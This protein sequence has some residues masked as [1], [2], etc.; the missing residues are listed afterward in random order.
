MSTVQSHTRNTPMKLVIRVPSSN[1]SQKAIHRQ[2]MNAGL[3]HH[4][5]LANDANAAGL[6]QKLAHARASARMQGASFIWLKKALSAGEDAMQQWSM[7]EKRSAPQWAVD[8]YRTFWGKVATIYAARLQSFGKSTDLGT[9]ESLPT[10]LVKDGICPTVITI[11]GTPFLFKACRYKMEKDKSCGNG[12]FYLKHPKSLRR[13]K[14]K[15]GKHEDREFKRVEKSWSSNIMRQNPG[16]RWV[17][18]TDASSPLHGRHI[19]IVP[20]A[21]GTASIVWAPEHSGLT[22]KILQPKRKEVETEETKREKLEAEKKREEAKAKRREEMPEEQIEK[23]EEQRKEVKAGRAKA[24]GKL[25]EMIR[26]KAGVETEVTAKERRA[27]EKKIEKLSKPEQQVE[28]LREINEIHRERRKALNEIIADAKKVML[29]E[30][31]GID[32]QHADDKKKIA[33]VIRDN[34]EEFLQAHYAIKAHERTLKVVNKQLRTGMV[35][36]AGTDIIGITEI[37]KEDLHRMVSD[38]KALSDEIAAHYDLIVQTRGGIDQDGKEITGT[39][40]GR[41]DMDKMIA[42]GSL[43]AINGITGEMTGTSMIS[44][45]FM[46]ELGGGNAAILA[47]YYLRNTLG[48]DDYTHHIEHF[49]EYIERKGNEIALDAVQKGDKYLEQAKRVGKF[50]QGEGMLFATRQQGAAAKLAYVNRAYLAYGQAEGGLHMAAEL[51]YQFQA[52]KKDLMI[53]SSNRPALNAKMKRLGLNAGDVRIERHGHGDYSMHIKPSAYEKMI[54]EKVVA[55]YK[56]ITEEPSPQSIKMQRENQAEWLPV[57][58]KSFITNKDGSMD[59]IIPAGE[60]QA[61]ARLVAFQKKVYLNHAPGVGKSFS[62]ILAKAHIE[63]QTGKPVKTVISMPKKLMGNFAEEVK[64]FSD[65]KVVIVDHSDQSKRAEAYKAD[66]NT[67]VL[68]NK[69]KFYFDHDLV[70]SAGFNMVIADEAHKITQR[71]ITGTKGIEIGSKMS[72]GLAKIAKDV[73]YYV[74]G[75]G[76]PSPNDLSE[77]HFHLNIMDPQKYSNKQEFMEKYRHL[78]KGAGLKEKLQNILNAELDDRIYTIEKTVAGAN[79]NYQAHSADLAPKQRIEYQRIQKRFLKGRINAMGR[80]QR[81]SRILNDFNHKENPKYV[82]MKKIIDSH[83]ANKGK[84][85]KV[86]IYAKN[87]STV[88]EI[89]KFVRANYPGKKVVRFTGVD[90]DGRPMSQAR[91]AAAKKSYLKD[92]N[93]LF[94]VHTDA[95]TEGLNLQHT[96]EADRPFGATTVI[97]MASGAHSWSTL[98]QF[99]SRGYRRGANKD[100]HGHLILTDTPHDMATEERLSEKKAVMSMLHEGSQLDEMAALK[101]KV[102]A[103]SASYRLRGTAGVQKSILIRRRIYA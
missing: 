36:H 23:L 21:N 32:E 80:D 52:H 45:D 83:V 39:G 25:H 11:P 74:A 47:D 35:T 5:R 92:P 34:A 1:R 15:D 13:Y 12:E 73:E 64:K 50:T 102:A 10:R 30:E 81:I 103:A 101:Q 29:G 78:H 51:L 91:I 70:K 66:P 58:I 3:R 88:S 49:N 84:S 75:S 18:I 71:D 33:Q 28:R 16:A 82:Q 42:Q 19:L 63:E 87:Y 100:V 65:Y 98:D 95:G 68:V 6:R 41:K 54:K 53:K 76:T 20:H 31:I 62:Y 86:L 44:E 56:Q 61:S 40:A 90:K 7:Y 48:E 69:E 4:Q 38:E 79:F 89:E 26:E 94:A 14:V 93:V 2:A 99:F 77:L 17:T 46:Q 60:Q 97:A 37:T 9:P 67:I 59:K 72:R 27:I 8:E 57:G 22:H 96:G 43:E 24:K 55:Q 85:E